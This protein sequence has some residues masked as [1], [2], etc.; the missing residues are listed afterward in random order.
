MTNFPT[1]L[2]A[3][4]NPTASDFLDTPAVRH[5]EQHANIND[6]VEAVQAKLGIDSSAVTTTIDYRMRQIEG[7]VGAGTFRVKAGIGYL[8][9]PNTGLWHRINPVVV[10][11]LLNFE[12]AP[13]GEA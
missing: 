12:I 9:N 5:D 6:A 7:A 8:K 4:T 11:S 1:A 2:D 10:D 13:T 3:F